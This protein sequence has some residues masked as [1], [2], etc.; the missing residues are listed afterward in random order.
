MPKTKR[1]A[2]LLLDIG[3]VKF[4]VAHPFTLTSGLKSPIYCDNR[5]LFSF[6]EARDLV[7]HS[8]LQKC[9]AL[10][11][12]DIVAGTAVAG[13]PWAAWLADRLQLPFVFVR[14]EPKGHGTKKTVEG[15]LPKGKRV[16]VIEDH[17]STAASALQCVANLRGEGQAIVDDVVSITSAQLDQ[18]EVSAGELGVQLHPLCTFTDILNAAKAQDL[19][20]REE[21]E[22]VVRY[23]ADPEQ[24]GS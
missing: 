15:N 16:V 20:S 1:L 7:I 2:E 4:S 24:W 22:S 10:S 8:F 19:V 12:I 3:C 9:N 21:C 6:P 11:A 23:I 18:A 14:R 13:I 17:L 5:L